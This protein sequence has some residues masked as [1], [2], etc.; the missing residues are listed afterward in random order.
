MI[1]F[2]TGAPGS[3]KTVLAVYRMAKDTR[4]IHTNIDLYDTS[5]IEFTKFIWEDFLK[6]IIELFSHQDDSH[7]YIA[8][9]KE[10]GIYGISIYFDECH[11]KLDRQKKEIVW[12][13]SI[14]RHLD[15]NIFL[16][17]QNK[18]IVA[19]KYRL[20]PEIFIFAH[21]ASTRFLSSTMRYSEYSSFSMNKNDRIRKFSHKYDKKYF[22]YY[23]TGAHNKGTNTLRKK[24]YTILA[25]ALVPILFLYFFMTSFSSSQ[26][27]KDLDKPE[28]VSSLK[29]KKSIK[30]IKKS[31][32]YIEVGLSDKYLNINGWLF[33][34]SLKNVQNLLQTPHK[35]FRLCDTYHTLYFRADNKFILLLLSSKDSNSF[36]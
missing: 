12:W 34:V 14:H 35:S 36:Q 2:L 6:N 9:A 23:R 5:P 13:L 25:F 8:M 19:Q 24:V 16:I 27:K 26:D 29:K 20:F 18:G 1:T 28:V 22:S 11:T 33:S 31:I 7:K 10:M 15:Q 32:P 4:E 21:T 17:T 3:G 30:K